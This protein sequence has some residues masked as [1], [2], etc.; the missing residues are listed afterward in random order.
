MHFAHDSLLDESIVDHVLVVVSA[1]STE[2]VNEGPSLEL[3]GKVLSKAVFKLVDFQ[4]TIMVVIDV[5]D[6]SP[7]LSHV[8]GISCHSLADVVLIDLLLPL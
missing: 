3:R 8:V 6:R 1:P 4:E 5:L 7:H 2:E